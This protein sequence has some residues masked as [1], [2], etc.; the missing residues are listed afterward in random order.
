MRRSDS[1][2]D[3]SEA[4]A[5][6]KARAL[7][8]APVSRETEQRLDR[9]VA[10]LLQ[11]QRTTNLIA[12][13]TV[14]EIW[15][16]HIAD[17]LQLLPL[18]PHARHYVDLG[19]GGG[20][21]GLVIACAL[22]G[23]ADSSIELVE[24]NHKKA[25]FLREAAR[26]TGTAAIVNAKRIE[27]FVPGA[28]RADV[29]TARALAPLETLL[30]LAHPL[31]QQGATGLFLKGQDVASEIQDATRCW[32]IEADLVQSRT[33]PDGRIVVVRQIGAANTVEA[34]PRMDHR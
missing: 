22:A 16:R 24:S 8:L 34:P 19:S 32:E 2:D 30:R 10:L 6:D 4:L 17:S 13:S 21:P 15:T 3:I 26:A 14:R 18:V 11:W 1:T 27:D 25:A 9:F 28:R 29:V 33:N 23:T 20:F 31:L 5:A 7:R 12:P